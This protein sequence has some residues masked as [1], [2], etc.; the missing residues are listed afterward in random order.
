MSG[1]GPGTSQSGNSSS[2]GDTAGGLA[3]QGGTQEWDPFHFPMRQPSSLCL[4]RVQRDIAQIHRDPPPG[5]FVFPDER[6]STVVHCLLVG[7]AETPYEG[8]MFYFYMACPDDYPTRPPRVKIMTG[9]G[10]CR[11]NPNL[12]ENGKVCMS[13]LNTWS[14]PSW[15]PVHSIASVLMSIQSLMGDRPYHNEPGYET[16]RYP[17]DVQAYN[18]VVQHE[19]LRHAVLGMMVKLGQGQLP[20]PFREV[21]EE[22]FM[23]MFEAYEEVCEDNLRR[24]GEPFRDPFRT[25]LGRFQYGAIL[26][27]LRRVREGLQRNSAFGEGEK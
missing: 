25:N 8:G 13:I 7:T 23:T 2:S 11:F 1:S 22:I 5:C 20:G 4:R 18:S 27:Q 26:E 24:D 21:M 9:M 3:A 17:G 16:E 19:T 12:Y 14:G 10:E 15:Q 6:Q